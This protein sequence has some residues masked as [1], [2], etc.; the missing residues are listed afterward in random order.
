[1]ID[2]IGHLIDDPII[3]LS[4]GGD[5]DFHDFLAHLFEDLIFAI[6]K[7]FGGVGTR[8]WIELARLD[9]GKE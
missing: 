9:G 5:D 1:M 3:A 2:Q 4:L 8:G 7:E 6:R